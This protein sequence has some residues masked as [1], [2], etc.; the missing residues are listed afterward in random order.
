MNIKTLEY[1][2]QTAQ[3][4]SISKTAEQLLFSQ[5]Y[6][7]GC[8]RNLEKELGFQIFIRERNGV[9]L[10]E[11]GKQF[12]PRAYRILDEIEAI[13]L[14]SAE[15]EEE[16]LNIAL[17]PLSYV[18]NAFL[19]F[20]K[21]SREKVS[22][23]FQEYIDYE[24]C[25]V[26]A[27]GKHRMGIFMKAEK[28]SELTSNILKKYQLQCEA[29]IPPQPYYAAASPTHPLALKKSLKR[30]MLALYPMVYYQLSITNQPPGWLGIAKLHPDSVAVGERG[31]YFDAL[32]SGEYFAVV[33]V[34]N[35]STR[36]GLIYIPI[37]DMELT[38]ALDCI[39]PKNYRL[40][41]RERRFLEYIKDALID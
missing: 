39:Y 25:E 6:L 23:K 37:E 29:V 36:Y 16:P 34:H 17:P 30:E 8:I 2:V 40:N 21:E 19:K 15:Q 32:L 5:P 14:L 7:S 9:K 28:Y 18:M 13:R 22:D 38:L 31:Q 35:I 20:T 41:S 4:G 24:I 27:S 10:T 12:L 26:V 11:K 33:T 1:A 3:T